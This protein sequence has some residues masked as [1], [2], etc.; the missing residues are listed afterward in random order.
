MESVDCEEIKPRDDEKW[1]YITLRRRS[2]G[3]P[4]TPANIS[5]DFQ[6]C[7]LRGSFHGLTVHKDATTN[8]TIQ[9]SWR[10][11]RVEWEGDDLAEEGQRLSV[12]ETLD[13]NGYPFLLV[14]VIEDDGPRGHAYQMVAKRQESD[15]DLDD[16]RSWE[17]LT[18][19][20]KYR[21]GIALS[22]KSVQSM[23]TEDSDDSGDSE[24]SGASDEDDEEVVE[25]KRKASG[26]DGNDKPAK[27][28]RR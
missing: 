10:I 19:D 28:I 25:K 6:L 14:W 4:A 23:A 17:P 11:K 26:P 16:D 22:D 5:G 12:S 2:K 9:N 3:K 24:D 13:D 27:E 7:I 21:L 18:Q 1:G 8:K 20:E 15:I